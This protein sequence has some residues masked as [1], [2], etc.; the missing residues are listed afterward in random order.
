MKKQEHDE[1]QPQSGFGQ[2][3]AFKVSGSVEK[4]RQHSKINDQY[5]PGGEAV[6]FKQHITGII[7]KPD[8][9][10]QRLRE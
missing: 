10:F 4:T 2:Y 5:K 7:A 6:N 3:V 8:C 9:Q 1:V